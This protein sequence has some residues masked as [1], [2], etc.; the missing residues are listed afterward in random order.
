[1]YDERTIQTDN[2][3]MLLIPTLLEFLDMKY[4]GSPFNFPPFFS[5][6]KKTKPHIIEN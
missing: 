6:H 1:M 3:Q 5:T 4:P 2:V